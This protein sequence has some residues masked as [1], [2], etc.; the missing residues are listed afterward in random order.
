MIK[1]LL[2]EDEAI[3]REELSEWLTFEGYHVINAEDGVAG[4]NAAFRHLP[5]LIICDITMPRLDGY[6]VLL[7][8]H[9][10]PSTVHI[11]FIF[12]TARASH[13]DI[14]QGM[15]LGADDY[16]TK[17]FSRIEFL[18]A[19]T[20]RL[21]K[22]VVQEQKHER[23]IQNIQ[24]ALNQEREERLLEAKLVAMFS[25][26]FR[27]PLATILASSNLLYKYPQM[28]EQ[29]RT[30]SFNRIEASVNQLNQMLE[31]MLIIAQMETNVLAFDPHP[32]RLDQLFHDIVEEFRTIYG[33]AHLI[34]YE[35]QFAE[36]IRADARL[37]RQI[38]TNLISNAIKYSPQ[39]GDIEVKLYKDTN[40]I[41]F[42]IY[43]SGIGIPSEDLPHL[44]EAFQRGSNVARISGTGLGLAIVKEAINKHSG[45]I[46]VTSEV[47]KGSQFTVQIPIVYT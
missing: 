42:S 2:I 40:H 12:M 25:H 24:A 3:L 15:V 27:N 32:M 21:E 35:S 11:P 36:I 18:Q 4:L 16:I 14:R 5:D 10:N 34:H 30:A 23:E 43:D 41:I 1:I 8:L 31:D 39:G 46:Q 19:I 37:L 9:A 26:D 28:D 13:E 7:E 45:D 38:A 44:F 47:G 20:T 22:K 6:S 33:E 17:P 29:R